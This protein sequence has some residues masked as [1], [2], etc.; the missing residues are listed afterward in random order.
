MLWAVKHI[1]GGLVDGYSAAAGGCIRNLPRVQTQSIK[2]KFA[3]SHGVSVWGQGAA[4]GDDAGVNTKP[5]Q[6]AKQTGVLDLDAAVNHH[7]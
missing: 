5:T 6:S 2:T 3:I 7:G 4:S 1:R